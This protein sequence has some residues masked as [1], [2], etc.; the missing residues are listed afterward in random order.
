VTRS[1]FVRPLVAMVVFMPSCAIVT[2]GCAATPAAEAAKAAECAA[3][4]EFY[5]EASDKL[6]AAG[7]CDA[8]ERV[9]DCAPYALLEEVY[10]A[11]M[12]ERRCAS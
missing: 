7:Q 2:G 4:K 11:T 1:R 12:L 10:V 5:E 9:E 8:H 3:V 6:I